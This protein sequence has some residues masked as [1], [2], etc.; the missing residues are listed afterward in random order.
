[1]ASSTA[2]GQSNGR[3]RCIHAFIQSIFKVGNNAAKGTNTAACSLPNRHRHTA[4]KQTGGTA[5]A[6]L[7]R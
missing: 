4:A 5:T 7:P 1:M 3:G 2:R 6:V